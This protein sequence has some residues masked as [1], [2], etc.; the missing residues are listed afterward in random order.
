M[1]LKCFRFDFPYSLLVGTVTVVALVTIQPAVFAAKSQQEIGDI[2][3]EVTVQINSSQEKNYGGSGVIIGRQGNTYTVLTCIHVL[4][5]SNRPGADLPGLAVRTQSQQT[6]PLTIVK[7]LGTRQT[8]DLAIVS[9]TTSTPTDYA[10]A[11]TAN[12]DAAKINS[13]IFVFGYPALA[14]KVKENRKYQF[15]T[16]TVVR[17]DSIGL[18]KGMEPYTLRYTAPTLG[19]MS[20]GPVFDVDGRVV[21]IHGAG[22]EAELEGGLRLKT[23]VNGGVPINTYKALR[24]QIGQSIP[25]LVVDN[26]PSTD[27]P[28]E[29][30]KNPQSAS[31]FLGKGLVQN[32]QGDE[33]QAIDAYTQAI[34]REPNYAD[35]YYHRANARYNQGDQQ[36]ALEDYTQAI[37]LN[38]DYANAYYQRG[39]IRYNQGDKQGALAD[40]GQ[41]ISLSPEDIQGYYNRGITRRALRDAQGTFEDFDQIVRLAFDDARSYY[42]RGLAR[43]DLRDREGALEDFNQAI[44]LDPS[45]NVAYNTRAMLRRR[46]GDR[47]GAIEDFSE[48]LRLDPRD[49]IAYFN[50][51][52][53]RR[54]LGDR[55]GAIED[56]Q[57]AADLFQ[58]QGDNNNYQKALEKIQSIEATPVAPVTTQP[59]FSSDFGQP[60]PDDPVTEQVESWDNSGW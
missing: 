28:E 60:T 7:K 49:G 4:E 14:N 8:S 42:N 48:I 44:S 6:Y 27:K 30:L 46:M 55:E 56:L 5:F 31:D 29:R 10:V 26:T 1:N 35:A 3:K 41:Y 38:P 20:G 59:D 57:S 58:Q 51:G 36:G 43:S 22:D 19:G 15:A 21:G 9:F 40:F 50:R 39:V 18:P 52:L 24:S 25:D 23:G 12:S 33:S 13:Q 2:A 53:V 34:S 54:D 17:R 11:K 37:S 45:W 47:E 32:A 16:G